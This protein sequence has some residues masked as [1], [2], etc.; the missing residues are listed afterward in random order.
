M[1]LS[2]MER[3]KML[4]NDDEWPVSPPAH[5]DEELRAA[6]PDGSRAENPV[7]SEFVYNLLHGPGRPA[8]KVD[9]HVKLDYS[10]TIPGPHDLSKHCQ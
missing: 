9:D 8:A 10:F 6:A 4:M 5:T 7:S 2:K 3:L 1:A